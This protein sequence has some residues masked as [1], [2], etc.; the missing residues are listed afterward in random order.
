[1]ASGDFDGLA[2]D[3][4]NLYREESYTDL[5]VGSFRKLIPIKLDGSVDAARAVIFTASTHVMS[6]AGP[7]PVNCELK[8]TSL[9]EA[10][11][12]FPAAVEEAVKQMIEEARQYRQDASSRIVVPEAGAMPGGRIQMP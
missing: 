10:V 7:L 5:R 8:A 12:E 3:A 2:V 11:K 1:M 6:P 9:A 4:E